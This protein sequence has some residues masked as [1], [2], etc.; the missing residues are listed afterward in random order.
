[1][2]FDRAQPPLSFNLYFR[3]YCCVV[4]Y[5]RTRNKKKNNRQINNNSQTWKH[6]TNVRSNSATHNH[7]KVSIW[8]ALKINWNALPIARNY[9]LWRTISSNVLYVHMLRYLHGTA[10]MV[11]FNIRLHARTW[12]AE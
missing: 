9:K 1:M 12:C 8:M 5:E 11:L 10:N 3:C 6:G 2:R 4:D 7:H